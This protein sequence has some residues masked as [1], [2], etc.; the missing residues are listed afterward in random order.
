M[1]VRPDR[2]L[3]VEGFVVNLLNPKVA[4]FFLAFLPQFVDPRQG[5]VAAQTL[6]LG[7]TYVVLGM[8]SDGLYAIAGARVGRWI[9]TRRERRSTLRYV[10]GGVLIGLGV[11][12]LAVP[13]RV[14]PRLAVGRHRL[15]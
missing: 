11:L 4:L 2:R 14:R 1:P 5:S 6:E 10:E 3:F 15:R 8:M 13:A 7:A 9:A 12:A